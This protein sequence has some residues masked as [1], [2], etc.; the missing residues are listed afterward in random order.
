MR[1]TQK[2]IQHTMKES[3][4]LMKDLLR[5]KKNKFFKHM[6]L[7]SKSVC[8]DVLNYIVDKYNNT[9]HRSFE[10]QPIDG[11]FNSYVEYNV[12][13]NEKGPKFQVGDHVKISKNKNIFPKG[14]T[15]NWSGEVF[16]MSKTK[17][18]VSWTSAIS[19]LNVEEVGTFQEKALQ[20]TNQEELRIEK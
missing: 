2:C 5:F 18:T 15:Y 7:N 1:I 10:M 14:Y 13:S 4:L 16:V 12:G 8:F 6:A 19:D 9:Y 11:K 3:L 20:E 17:K